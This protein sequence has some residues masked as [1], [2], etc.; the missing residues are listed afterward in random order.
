MKKFEPSEMKAACLDVRKEIATIRDQAMS[1]SEKLRYLHRLYA[2]LFV[3][4]GVPC[5]VVAEAIGENRTT[6]QRWVKRFVEGGGVSELR[7]HSRTGRPSKLS[8]DDLARLRKDLDQNPMMSGYGKGKMRW[9]PALVSKHLEEHYGITLSVRQC[10]R[11]I[12]AMEPRPEAVRP[13]RF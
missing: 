12:D 11:M 4:Q 5:Q 8:G 2:M 13:S 7:D 3:F 6:V 10:R 1:E 9:S